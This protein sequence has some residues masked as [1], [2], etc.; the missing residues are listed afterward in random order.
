MNLNL[1]GPNK[2]RGFIELAVAGI[3]L[4]GGLVSGNKQRKAQNRARRAQQQANSL[5]NM[6]SYRNFMENYR[7]RR[8]MEAAQ[9][10]AAGTIG[11]SFANASQS[12]TQATARNAA[13]EFGQMNKLGAEASTQ[14]NKAA[15]AQFAGDMFGTVGAFANSQ[16]GGDLLDQADKFFGLG[17]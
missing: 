7:M 15:R 5:K 17:K 11:S 12:S 16:G 8:A 9:G 2:Q 3:S 14:M 13:S 4:V 1:K 10:L 6:Q